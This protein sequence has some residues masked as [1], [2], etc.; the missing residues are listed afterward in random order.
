MRRAVGRE[1]G[2]RL[3]GVARGG[4]LLIFRDTQ[5]GFEGPPR[6]PRG[7]GVFRTRLHVPDALRW[8]DGARTEALDLV[9]LRVAVGGF[10]EVLWGVR[11]GIGGGRKDGFGDGSPAVLDLL[12]DRLLSQGQMR[13]RRG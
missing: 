10:A 13:F 6:L 12:R 9:D 5:G 11:D 1:L 7:K 8:L 3:V 4:G 2:G